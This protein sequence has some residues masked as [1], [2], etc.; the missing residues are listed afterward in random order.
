MTGKGKGTVED[1]STAVAGPIRLGE[2]ICNDSIMA[3]HMDISGLNLVTDKASLLSSPETKPNRL[4]KSIVSAS[5]YEDIRGENKVILSNLIENEGQGSDEVG[6]LLSNGDQH[7]LR[8]QSVASDISSICAEELSAFEANLEINA[9]ALD[10]GKSSGDV[11]DVNLVPKHLVGEDGNGSNESDKIS[12]NSILEGAQQ[13]ELRRTASQILLELNN[14]PLWGYTSIC[15]RRPEMEDAVKA[16]PRFL[17]VPLQMLRDDIISN[18]AN[19]DISY[20]TAHFYGVYDGHGGCQVAN[21]CQERLH[22]ALEEEIEIAK[23]GLSGGN[24][25]QNWQD[26]WKKAFTNCFLKVDFEIGGNKMDLKPVAPE[27]VGSTALA[28]I[29]CP[30]HIIVSNCGD[31]RAVL[32]RGKVAVPLS[33]DHKPEREDEHARIEAAGGKV[34]QWNGYRVSGVLAMSRSIGDR[35]LKPCIIPDPE[36]MFVPRAKDDECFILAS[37]GLWDVMSNDEVC[38]IARKR[39]LLW[40]KKHGETL[41]AGRGEGADPAAQA[42]AEYLSRVALSKGSKDNISVIVVDLKAQRKFKRKN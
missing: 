37:D 32:R 14:T 3:S 23:S 20:L 41:S 12:C 29:L 7:I 42:A 19:C 1:I 6:C 24:M 38:D 10:R 9:I 8:S 26:K 39:I 4:R 31:S 33:V 36:I 13:K 27:T 17:Q 40:H 2:V 21:Y 11:Q 5:E 25:E 15:G 16:I 18:G 30:T 22:L 28:A 35:Y 34:I